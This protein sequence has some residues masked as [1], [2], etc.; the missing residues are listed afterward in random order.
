M[1]N[2]QGATSEGILHTLRIQLAGELYA[3][4]RT[5]SRRTELP[6]EL[7]ARGA[8]CGSAMPHLLNVGKLLQRVSKEW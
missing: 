1:K 4:M 5:C 7:Y 8:L 6:Q 3:D 2:D